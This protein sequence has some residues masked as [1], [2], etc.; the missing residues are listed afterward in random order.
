MDGALT[1]LW[2]AREFLAWAARQEERY[3]FDGQQPVAMTGGT[4]RHNRISHNIYLALGT[5]LRGKRC[6]PYD[7]T[8]VSRQSAKKSAARM[9]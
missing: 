7:L 4:A 6:T 3:E 2:T 8:W 5:R 1:T 9:P